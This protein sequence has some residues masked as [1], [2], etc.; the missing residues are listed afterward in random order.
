MY[1]QNILVKLKSIGL[2]I[3]QKRNEYKNINVK[4]IQ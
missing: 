1:F 3:L 2:P 4:V